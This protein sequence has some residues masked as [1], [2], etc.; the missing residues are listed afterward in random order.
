MIHIH[1]FGI[2]IYKYS[3]NGKENDFP[4]F[5]RC[6]NCN[7]LAQGNIYRHGYYW[8]Y[9]IEKGEHIQL[10]ICRYICKACKITI[11]ILP[12]FLIPYF[13]YT[14]HMIVEGVRRYLNGNKV[15]ATRQLIAQHW[16]R[17]SETLHWIHSYFVDKGHVSGLSQ[18]IKKE[19]LK[20]VRMIRDIGVSPFFR[21]SW[22][23]LSSYFMGR[24]ILP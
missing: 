14:L 7:C 2:D 11:S 6:P 5:D 20:Y 15:E 3:E 17:F 13:Q 16:R 12:S 1:D 18:D 23:H 19:A 9:G 24:L 22:G 8:R 4:A 10:A 21:R